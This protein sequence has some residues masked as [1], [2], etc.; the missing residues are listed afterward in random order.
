MGNKLFVIYFWSIL[1]VRFIA[2]QLEIEIFNLLAATSIILFCISIRCT[3]K[4]LRSFVIVTVCL[5]GVWLADFLFSGTFNY[6]LSKDLLIYGLLPC[7]F[8]SFVESIRF[9]SEF[10]KKVGLCV[11]ALYIQ[12]PFNNFYYTINYM[13][14]GSLLL[15][16]LGA[17]IIYTPFKHK[18]TNIIILSLIFSLALFSNRGTLLALFMYL[19]FQN[20]KLTLKSAVAFGAVM[21]FI[22]INILQII[23]SGLS[24][25]DTVEVYALRSFSRILE[26]D[27]SYDISSSRLYIWKDAIDILAN[28]Q[29]GIGH[30]NIVPIL[31]TYPHNIILDLLL[32][33]G[34]LFSG[35][36]VFI[37]C[38]RFQ[39]LFS[40]PKLRG[41][42]IFLLAN[43]LIFL[44]FSSRF[45]LNP[46]FWITMMVICM[47]K[48][49]IY[50]KLK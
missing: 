39:Y 46:F 49:Q 33:Y 41:V 22:T 32:S 40:N 2:L 15:L 31:G 35:I 10:H 9:F 20:Y 38:Y 37:F 23:R 21:T 17:A 4:N 47:N 7:Y 11:L 44:M 29:F 24:Y 30:S 6:V 43:W 26:K 34:I 12:E 13:V 45:T 3:N 18:I 19:I 42:F 14:F 28:N 1:I 50:E 25:F 27:I 5:I 48:N 16:P 36:A 8:F